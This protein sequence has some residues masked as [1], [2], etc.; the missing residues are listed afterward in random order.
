MTHLFIAT[1]LLGIFAAPVL[2]AQS[3]SL[4][5]KISVP[6]TLAATATGKP[7]NGKP[8]QYLVWQTPDPAWLRNRTLA[9]Y[10]KPGA[11]DAVTPYTFLGS[12]SVTRDPATLKILLDRG[13][14]LATGPDQNLRLGQ[15]ISE[16]TERW[17]IDGQV[18]PPTDEGKLSALIGRTLDSEEDA[19]TLRQVSISYPAI[20]LALGLGWAGPLPVADGS[21]ATIEVR[22]YD[23][24]GQRDLQVVGRV[25][26]QAGRAP[27]LAAPAEPE[28]VP[29]ISPEGNMNVKLRW[30]VPDSLRRQ[31]LQTTGFAVWRFSGPPPANPPS[32]AQIAAAFRLNRYPIE[33]AKLFTVAEAE[34]FTNDPTTFFVMDRG[35]DGNPLSAGFANEGNYHYAVAALD[36]L[37]QPGAISTAAFAHVIRTIPPPVPAGLGIEQI[38]SRPEA[39]AQLR[40][41]LTYDGIPSAPGNTVANRFAI[42][43][44]GGSDADSLKKLNQLLPK[45]EAPLPFGVVGT[46]PIGFMVN[47]P[48]R[49]KFN[50]NTLD[51]LETNFGLGFWYSVRSIRDTPLGSIYSAP[52]PPVFGTFH[53]RA[54]PSA[55]TGSLGTDAP[56]TL[57]RFLSQGTESNADGSK[58]I[59][60]G[61]FVRLKCLRADPNVRYVS[62]H[63]VDSRTNEKLL[64]SLK[65]VF[66]PGADQVFADYYWPDPAAAEIAGQVRRDNLVLICTA[67]S[68]GE[69][70]S[71]REFRPLSWINTG[72]ASDVNRSFIRF[73]AKIQADSQLNIGNVSAAPRLETPTVSS[74]V[75]TGNTVTMTFNSS[76]ANRKAI[77]RISRS[78]YATLTRISKVTASNKISFDDPLRTA[79]GVPAP[80]YDVRLRKDLQSP[81]PAGFI[82]EIWLPA[83]KD[84]GHLSTMP[85]NSGAPSLW[86]TLGLQTDSAE[87]RIYRQ[88]D[89]GSLGLIAEGNAD[90]L[91]GQANQ[92]VF[93]DKPNL[94]AS[95]TVCYFGQLFDSSGN[96]SP[97]KQIGECVQIIAPPPVPVLNEPEQLGT[98][99]APRMRAK[100]F[101]PKA[102][103]KRFHVR[104]V[105]TTTGS[106]VVN[107]SGGTKIANNK[108][109]GTYF[110]APGATGLP[111]LSF[112][113][114]VFLT[115]PS[116]PPSGAVP[117]P[118]D[119]PSVFTM[120][121]DVK[122][123]REYTVEVW[124]ESW[125]DSLGN[126]SLPQ[127]FTWRSVVPS[128]SVPWPARPLPPVIA[129]SP[130][131][132]RALAFTSQT[133]AGQG[134]F[135]YYS[136]EE[137]PVFVTLGFIPLLADGFSIGRVFLPTSGNTSFPLLTV[138]TSS[139]LYRGD[140]DP[141]AHLLNVLN[142][143]TKQ[144]SPATPVA[145][146]RQ[147]ISTQDRDTTQTADMVQVS[148]LI[149]SIAWLPQ[150]NNA[151]GIVD[152]HVLAIPSHNGTR[153]TSATLALADL[154]PILTSSTYRY[155]LVQ[156]DANGEIVQTIDAGT[157]TIQGAQAIGQ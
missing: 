127:K 56:V 30:A 119:E 53:D 118:A 134:P 3:S 36:W 20:R 144:L 23:V 137:Y 153:Y 71:F 157:V 87:Y 140:R 81:M 91:S 10:L 8:W 29:D 51:A 80:A 96:P 151:A 22:E 102:G 141:N 16:L 129:G 43:R 89:G 73:E 101:C 4:P 143:A 75:S 138:D 132:I 111:A 25:T 52:S 60:K 35:A 59:G 67:Y 106:E 61:R 76:L 154:H 45:P 19:I 54:A 66:G 6:S 14:T 50:D 97:L 107:S 72:G 133:E 135:P 120:V 40:F 117:P 65:V 31:N 46:S 34:N 100:W 105:D 139:M 37:G 70:P 63:V 123:D 148:P 79:P 13:R 95:G 103:V 146:Y 18:V 122:T 68:N 128:G 92:I 33:L 108:S 28:Q 55:P 39:A 24:P 99:A 125:A 124:A 2:H 93:E 47:G 150:P 38:F 44:G 110:N 147:L 42:Y 131:G 32:P 94:P 90:Y 57:I 126:R 48:G 7:I 21:T 78:G 83:L 112:N 9:L 88:V 121:F 130:F 145:L 109:S 15:V 1:L 12:S 74:T 64:S 155:F 115:G 152:Q 27:L 11:A 84:P 26:F 69:I 104:I 17:K 113:G 156:F 98:T 136:A 5:A 149:Q 82:G 114:A 85:D 41:R 58:S 77:I 116:V 49:L 142:P 62:F 86:V